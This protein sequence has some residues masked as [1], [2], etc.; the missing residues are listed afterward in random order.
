MSEFLNEMKKENYDVLMFIPG[1][2]EGEV[3]IE[4]NCF[5]DIGIKLDKGLSGDCFQVAIF[6]ESLTEDKIVELDV[7]DAVLS[8]PID[9]MERM[10]HSDW[11][12][13]ICRKTTTSLEFFTKSVDVFRTAC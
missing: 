1:D 2:N 8:S 11:Y 13:L 4:G 3:R 7:F 12:G 5:E 6:K 9:Y 10:M